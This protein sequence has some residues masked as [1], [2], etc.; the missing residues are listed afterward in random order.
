MTSKTISE[1]LTVGSCELGQ[2]DSSP[3]LQQ[4]LPILA[5]GLMFIICNFKIK[6]LW[7]WK[8]WAELKAGTLYLKSGFKWKCT[9]KFRNFSVFISYSAPS[10]L[11]GRTVPSW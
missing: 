4:H 1:N 8:N 10:T 7:T 3:L 11:V 5:K 6:G 9:T 2:G